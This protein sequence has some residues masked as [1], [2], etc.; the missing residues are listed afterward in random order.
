MSYR[1]GSSQR[2]TLTSASLKLLQ[3]T[4]SVDL[5]PQ[6]LKDAVQATR[7][8]GIRYLWVDALCILQDSPDDLV[9]EIAN[10]S[11]Y[12]RLAT[13]VIQPSGLTS[14]HD[15]FLSHPPKDN[16][17][18]VLKSLNVKR[19]RYLEM[20][21]DGQNGKTYPVILEANPRWYVPYQEPI[22]SRGWVLQ[23]RMLCPRVLIFP[24][25]GGMVW[26]CEEMERAHGKLL[27]G[28]MSGRNR[29]RLS[30]PSR[31]L[32][33]AI[34]EM[35]LT[36]DEIHHSWLTIVDDY[37]ER[38]LTYPDDKL[39]AISALAK[40]YADKYGEVLG[41]YCAGVWYNFLDRSLH[42]TYYGEHQPEQKPKRKRAPSWS[43]AASDKNMFW[44]KYAHKEGAPYRIEIL[45]CKVSLAS[46]ELPFGQV[47]HGKL[48]VRAMLLDVIWYPDGWLYDAS[49]SYF[50]T[51]TTTS[52]PLPETPPAESDRFGHAEPDFADYASTKPIRISYLPL[53]GHEGLLLA[54][55]REQDE[56]EAGATFIRVGICRLIGHQSTDKKQ[57]ERFKDR[58]RRVVVIE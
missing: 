32:R 15:P 23:E 39:V 31:R 21:F 36:P 47:K 55:Q 20:Q 58:E 57:L 27:Y 5:L 37:S 33:G 34:R 2:L 45:E 30:R 10:M 49:L 7:S 1:W 12:V 41:S 13:V 42:W 44:M 24:S 6:T 40:H 8:L 22:H 51:T 11:D 54:K 3:S 14:V 50:S 18:H 16:D 53:F 35:D 46:P 43:W 38:D 4:F 52:M 25:M 56:R 28:F 17:F 19:C 9:R 48:T 29:M 26:Q